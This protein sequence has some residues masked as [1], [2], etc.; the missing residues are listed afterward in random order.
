MKAII[1]KVSN[2]KLITFDLKDF[3]TK[4]IRIGLDLKEFYKNELFLR[5]K[6]FR[7]ELKKYSFNSFE[8]SFIYVYDSGKSIL[9]SWVVPLLVVHLAPISQFVTFGSLIDLER[10]LFLLKLSKVVFSVYENKKVIVKGCSEVYIPFSAYVY[11]VQNLQPYVSSLMY[12]EACSAVPL[13]KRK[14]ILN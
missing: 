11:V 12:G 13:Y 7:K 9:P 4:G 6:S 1:N 8:N 14:Q 3:Y 2:S 5:E 10:E